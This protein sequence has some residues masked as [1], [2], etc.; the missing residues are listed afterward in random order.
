M[1]GVAIVIFWAS[2]AA[3]AYTPVGYLLCLAVL[4]RLIR[5]P[6]KRGPIRPMVSIIVPVHNGAEV[7]DLKIANLRALDYPS[8]LLEIIFVDDCSTDDTWD[9]IR[10][11]KRIRLDRRQGKSAALNAGLEAATGEIIA[12]TDVGVMLEPD[13]LKVAVERFVDPKVGCVSSED[14]VISEG[15]VGEGEGFYTRLDTRIRRLESAICSV[16]GV[17]GSFYLVRRQL[18]PPFPPDL[19][20]DMFSGLHCVERGFRA[21][22]EERSK[23]RIC[24]QPDPSREFDRKVRTM[25]TGLRALK[26]FRR[27][28]NP[29]RAGIFVWFLI[30]HK[31]MR[32]LLPVFATGTVLSSAY[33]APSSLFFR[34]CLLAQV[35]AVS[36]G[37][38]QMLIRTS[39]LTRRIPG[40]PAFLCASLVAAAVG[41]YRFIA[42]ERYE[43]WQP[44]ERR[45]V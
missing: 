29:L 42:G 37:C 28:L 41:W 31:L 38:A 19:A 23:V 44:T 39:A 24:A 27:L 33:L 10:N 6:V 34:C 9:R 2:A 22:V 5:R 15:G 45:A 17:S 4:S 40:A 3:L 14:V 43:T 12:F 18:C 7:V 32:Y 8:D 11:V 35:V 25:V 36:I 20:T 21:V 30:S 26:S 1:T 16:A 13:S